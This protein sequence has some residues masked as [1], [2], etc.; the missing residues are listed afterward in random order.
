[1]ITFERE[2]SILISFEILVLFC[3]VHISFDTVL[4]YKQWLLLVHLLKKHH[5]RLGSMVNELVSFLINFLS[6][7]VLLA[8]YTYKIQTLKRISSEDKG[9]NH[10]D[11]KTWPIVCTQVLSGCHQRPTLIL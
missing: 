2:G 10:L 5:S 11:D 1:M 9:T 7:I 4:V 6:I 8:I 3:S